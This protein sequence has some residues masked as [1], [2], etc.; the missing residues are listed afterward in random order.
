[1]RPCKTFKDHL[2]FGGFFKSFLH[3]ANLENMNICVFDL[4]WVKFVIGVT[5]GK[6]QYRI[7]LKWLRLFFGLPKWPTK[8]V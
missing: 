7:H 8:A 4:I 3:F 6:E 1:M 2:D 5:L